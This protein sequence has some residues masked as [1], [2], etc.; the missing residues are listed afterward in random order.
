VRV[1]RETVSVALFNLLK[2]TQIGGLPAFQSTSR[3]AKVWSNT[4]QADQPAMFLIHSGEEAVQSQAY[5]LTKWMLHFEIL[6]YARVD[7]NPNGIPPDTTI[8]AILDAIDAQMQST[9]PGER[10]TLGNVVY[11]SWIEGQ[12]LID[13]GILDQQI[14]I[15]VPVRVLTGI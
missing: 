5:G 2:A 8:N 3:K 6:I 12:I 4:N 14:A 1:P 7:S 10:Q 9:P 13:T 15:L 11:H